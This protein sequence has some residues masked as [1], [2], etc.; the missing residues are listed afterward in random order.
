MPEIPSTQEEEV[1]G[2][3]SEAGPSKVSVIPYL[4]NKLKAKDQGHSSVGGHVGGP[5]LVCST[6]TKKDKTK[7]K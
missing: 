6:E 4:K 5:G 3:L 7:P 2:S 1:G